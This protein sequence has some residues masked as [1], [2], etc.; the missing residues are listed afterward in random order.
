MAFATSSKVAHP[1]YSIV[2]ELETLNNGKPIKVARDFDISDSIRWPTV[3][4]Y[5]MRLPS[6]TGWGDKILEEVRTLRP[7]T[8]IYPG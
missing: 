3:Q 8:P 2:T 7:F 4:E 1:I 6:V 5:Y